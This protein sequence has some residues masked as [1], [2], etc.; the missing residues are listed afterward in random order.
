MK[1]EASKILLNK[2]LLEMKDGIYSDTDRLPPEVELS[3]KFGVS[4][5]VVRDALAVL[6]REGFVNRK[7]GIGTV[8]NRRI[9]GL[10]SRLDMEK[11]FLE[12]LRDEGYQAEVAWSYYECIPADEKVRLR[13]ELQEKDTVFAIYRLITANKQPVIY[14]V[15]YVSTKLVKKEECNLE[16]LNEPVFNFL[17]SECDAYVKMDVTEVD[18]VKAD[19]TVSKML[20]VEIGQP[21]LYMDEIGYDFYAAP[22]LYAQEY[23]V[24][25]ILHH[26]LIRKKM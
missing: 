8:I 3:H 5:T 14:C 13:L 11:E 7:H 20:K 6:E 19:E 4:R 10:S 17:E 2:L 9:L 16:L 26:T 18:A 23:Y 24:P 25:G 12:M 22:I 1:D 21:L 15:D